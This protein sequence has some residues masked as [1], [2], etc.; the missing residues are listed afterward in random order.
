MNIAG[1][2][3]CIVFVCTLLVLYFFFYADAVAQNFDMP[4]TKK[5]NH[6][7]MSSHLQKLETTR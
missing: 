6:P 1:F 4:P 3:N 7:K 2:K 5:N